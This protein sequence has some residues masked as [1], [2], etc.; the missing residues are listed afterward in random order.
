[1]LLVGLTGSIGSGKTTVARLFS[2]L[3]IPVYRADDASRRLLLDDATIHRAIRKRFGDTV[4]RDGRPDPRALAGI[5]FS[6]PRALRDLNAILHPAV[7][8]DFEAWTRRQQAPYA[9]QEAAILYEAGADRGLDRVVA[10]TAPEALRRARTRGRYGDAPEQFD[11]RQG[12]QWSEDRKAE[13]AD[14]IIRNDETQPVIPQV[15][16][17]H[18]ALLAL[19]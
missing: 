2:L 3:G 9:V 15:I 19:G 13:K 5:V 10:V 7:A 4:F 14:F 8:A 12:Q 17:I 16:A 6:D 11:L 18:H 1:M